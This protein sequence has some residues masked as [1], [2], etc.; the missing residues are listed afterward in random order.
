MLRLS[1]GRSTAAVLVF[2]SA[3]ALATAHARPVAAQNW[4]EAPV[5]GTIELAAGFLPDPVSRSLQAGGGDT[6]AIP[7]V[8]CAGHINAAAPDYRL[9]YTAGDGPLYVY[10]R[11][12]SDVT[13]LVHD[14]A[15]E[16]HCSDDWQGTDPMISFETPLDGSYAVWVGTYAA[17]AL[18]EASLHFSEIDPSIDA[19][20]LASAFAEFGEG[21]PDISAMPVYETLQLSSGFLPD[22]VVRELHAGGADPNPVEGDGCRGFIN[23]GAPDFDLNYSA[24]S[25]PL[26]IYARSDADLTL[27]VNDAH[28]A[29]HCSDDV[30]GTHPV[31]RLDGPPSGN[32]NIWVGTYQAGELQPATLYVSERAPR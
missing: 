6:N 19:D 21:M 32:Y 29:W 7:A 3:L 24:G 31:I 28:G 11:S 2:A 18:Q 5:Y 13:L 9:S 22:P 10:A 16:W 26:Y 23:L 17:G 1:L 14:P 20:E 27:V 30:D 8:G 4:K 12:R 25:M 15:G